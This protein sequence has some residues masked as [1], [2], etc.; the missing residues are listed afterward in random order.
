MVLAWEWP[1]VAASEGFVCGPPYPLTWRLVNRCNAS[2]SRA[3]AI[4][5]AS[6]ILPTGRSVDRRE[7]QTEDA[8]SWGKSASG[9]RD[10]G[11]CRDCG[12]IG[13][14]PITKQQEPRDRAPEQGVDPPEERETPPA[15]QR[16]DAAAVEGVN[17]AMEGA[18]E[19][20]RK[21]GAEE[22]KGSDNARRQN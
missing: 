22:E 11:H 21:A 15:K 17:H 5:R 1:P 19:R 14:T 18:Y 2:T 12:R 6:E 16:K 4:P 10:S 13:L 3:I 20:K 8:S 9:L 7:E